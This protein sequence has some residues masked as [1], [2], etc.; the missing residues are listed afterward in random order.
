MFR[1]VQRKTQIIFDD[2][3]GKWNYRAI[4]STKCRK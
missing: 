3:L 4:P 2:F 1:E